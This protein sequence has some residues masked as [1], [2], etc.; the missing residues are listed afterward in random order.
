MKIGVYHNLGAGGAKISLNNLINT[1]SKDNEVHI[2]THSQEYLS[3]NNKNVHVH[4]Y[5]LATP[6][7]I[8]D[9]LWLTLFSLHRICMKVAKDMLN[10]GLDLIIIGQ[11]RYTQS[12][13][14]LR[15][16]GSLKSKS[17]YMFNEPLREFYEPTTLDH[18][19][20]K[21]T[22]SRIIKRPIKYL[23]YINCQFAKKIVCCSSY[24]QTQ[25]RD[26]YK[27]D[28]IVIWPGVKKIKPVKVSR[29]NNRRICS[30]GLLT[31]LKGHDFSIEQVKDKRLD[32]LGNLSHESN[33][34]FAKS[35]GRKNIRIV[36]NNSEGYKDKFLRLHSIYLANNVRE[37]FGLATVEAME[38]NCCVLGVS[39]GGTSELIK[40]KFNGYLYRRDIIESQHVLDEIYNKKILTFYKCFAIDW[41]HTAKQIL[42]Y[43]NKNK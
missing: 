39:E 29:P 40:H 31:S 8:F 35:I 10:T 14:I 30:V 28:G 6:S 22:L 24:S 7:S 3:W 38:A 17:V 9:L 20:L 2:Y 27:K 33:V 11:C 18:H 32:I 13:N 16:L 12:P 4:N 36:H 25:L 37:P 15:H 43:A 5:D 23:D 41:Y 21:R 34:I 19:S 1:L 42:R 26:I